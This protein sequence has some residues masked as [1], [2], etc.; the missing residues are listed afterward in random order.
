MDPPCV[1]SLHS[2]ADEYLGLPPPPK[3]EKAALRQH[4]RRE[5]AFAFLH[6]HVTDGRL[7]GMLDQIA[8]GPTPEEGKAR[9]AWRLIRK[10]CGGPENDTDSLVS[11]FERTRRDLYT[12]V[13]HRDWPLEDSSLAHFV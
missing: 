13:S 6:D 10:E 8:E 2:F 5:Q 7:K 11:S 9:A 1:L 4:R 12:N 3:S